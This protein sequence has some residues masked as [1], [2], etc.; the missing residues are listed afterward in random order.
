MILCRDGKLTFHEMNT[1][2]RRPVPVPEVSPPAGK[3]VL[4]MDQAMAG[5][6]RSI[7]ELTNGK[8]KGK[9]GAAELLEMNPSTLR[10]RMNK[11]GIKT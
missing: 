6:I 4:N 7:L 3:A 5:H 8:I 9:G 1:I 2:A 11:L 10:F